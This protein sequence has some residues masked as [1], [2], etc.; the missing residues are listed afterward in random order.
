MEN[1][2]TIVPISMS[3]KKLFKWFYPTPEVLVREAINEIIVANR[4][5]L[6]KNENKTDKQLIRTKTVYKPEILKLFD[7]LGCPFE[8]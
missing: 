2:N 8:I 6:L 4:K 1:K 5:K 3:K 7:V